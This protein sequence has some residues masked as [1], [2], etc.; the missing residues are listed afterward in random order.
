MRATAKT[1]SLWPLAAMVVASLPLATAA[2]SS[3]AMMPLTG[4]SL[5]I[6]MNATDG[7]AGSQPFMA[8]EP[9][10]RAVIYRP[11][12]QELFRWRRRVSFVATA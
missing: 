8:A 9:W 12:G 11:D 3:S 7:D 4:V 1:W 5:V 6:D 2:Q 10:R